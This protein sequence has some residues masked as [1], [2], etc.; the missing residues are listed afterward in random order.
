VAR[1]VRVWHGV[2][3]LG[4]GGMRKRLN[5]IWRQQ[6]VML[7]RASY[8]R[9]EHQWERHARERALATGAAGAEATQVERAEAEVITRGERG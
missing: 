2:K 6:P 4:V 3:D 9:A 7:H 1:R 5:V 8:R